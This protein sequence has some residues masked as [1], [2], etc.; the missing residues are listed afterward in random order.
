MP[1]EVQEDY[2]VRRFSLDVWKKILREAR[3][4]SK[5]MFGLIACAVILAV[6]DSTFTL[7]TRWVINDLQTGGAD[8][9]FV[10]HI[11]TYA[12]L[13][14]CFAL[15]VAVFIHLGGKISTHLSYDIRQKGFIRLQ[16]LSFSF[17]DKRSVGWLVTRLTGDCD[18]LTRILAWGTLDIVWGGM[19]IVAIAVISLVLNWRLA[20]LMLL[21]VPPMAWISLV[22]QRKILHISRKVRRT[23]SNITAAHNESIAGVRTTRSLVRED[24][25]LAE[26]KSLTTTMYDSSVHNALLSAMFLPI[27]LTVGSLAVGVSLWRGGTIALTD[28]GRIGEMVVFVNFSLMLFVP[29]Q[30]MAARFVDIQACQAAAERVMD[31]LEIE[32]EIRDSDEVV[33]AINSRPRGE[34]PAGVAI[35]GG[36]SEIH[37]IEFRGVSFAYDGGQAVLHDFN[38]DVRRGRTVALVGPTGGGKSTIVSLL[39]RFYEPTEGRILINGVD[40]RQ[41]SLHWL[42]SSLGMVLQTPHVFSCSVADN[43]RYGRLDATDDEVAHAAELVNAGA[44]IRQMDDGYQTQVGEGGVKLS[45]GQKQLISLARAVLADPQLFVMDEATSSV[46]TDTECLIQRGLANVLGG[47][48]SFVIAH[49]LSTIRSADRILVIDGGQ[50]VEQGD[51]HDL[52]ALKGRYYQLYTNQFTREKQDEIFQGS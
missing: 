29:I 12:T 14:V 45:T 32:P 22:F 1:L 43:I 25:N 8:V 21:V 26:F 5:C 51:H 36:D 41:R 13:A 28:P 16:E 44:F 3:P 23:N 33:R 24:A 35:D 19:L 46:D 42:Q 52:I 50:I 48:I 17:Y 9:S 34:R 30:E 4:Y 47:R 2:A 31:L 11:C 18:R 6:I 10:P 49:R 7:V 40:Y 15:C 38:M 20:I 37:R 27:I 39:C